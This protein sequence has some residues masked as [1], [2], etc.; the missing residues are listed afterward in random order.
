MLVTGSSRGIGRALVEHYVDRGHSVFG[1]SRSESDFVHR[2]YHHLIADVADESAVRRAF[3]QIAKDSGRLDVLINNAGLKIGSYALLTTGKQ[4]ESMLRTNLLGAFWVTRDAVKLMKRNRFG[5]VVSLSS[6]AVP[7]GSEGSAIYGAGK[8]GLEQLSHTLARELAADD[9]TFNT[10]G[11]SVYENSGMVAG[12]KEDV[13]REARR[14]LIKPAP[15][16]IEEIAH[17]TD[18]FVS[19]MARNI[20]NQVVYFGGVR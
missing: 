7:L 5:R 13:L 19:D 3:S 1:L 16:S 6:V 12:L 8:A 11:I 2:Q 18:F 20:T 9:I 14:S 10:I 4:A 15:L 17:A